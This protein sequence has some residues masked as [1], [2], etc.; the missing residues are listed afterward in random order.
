MNRAISKSSESDKYNVPGLEKGLEIIERLSKYPEGHTLGELCEELGIAQTTAYRMLSTLVRKE[1][2]LFD[3]SGKRYRLSQK[4]LALGQSAFRKNSLL[5]AVLPRLRELRDNVSETTCFG[6]LS[7][8]QG[9]LIEQ[10][11]GDSAFCHVLSPGKL[12]ELHCS[13]P[14]KAILAFLPKVER[15]RY[16]A[17]MAFTRYNDRTITNADDFRVE[18]ITVLNGGYAL[19]N[20]EELGGVMCIGAPILNHIGYPCGAI[21][22]TGPK[23]RIMNIGLDHYVKA[24]KAVAQS[25]ARDMGYNVK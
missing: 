11:Q 24:V 9:V 10:V 6:V 14:G 7:G 4:L 12:F 2:L 23:D 21:W 19:D 15:E 3:E 1:Y 16:I 13:A 22:T 18:L 8:D 20:E 5:E 25:V 17:K